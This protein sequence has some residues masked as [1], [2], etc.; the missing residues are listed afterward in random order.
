MNEHLSRQFEL[1]LDAIRTEA[2]Q[3]GGLV[4]QQLAAALSGLVSADLDLL[5]KVAR[6]EDRV[7]R[8]E[9]DIDQACTRLIA[10]RQPTASDLRLVMGVSRIVTDLERCGDKAA[11]IARMAVKLHRGRE[12]TAAVPQLSNLRRFGE[13]AVALLRRT[14]DALARLD[15]DEAAQIIGADKALDEMFESILRE[16]IT[17]MMEDSRT[18]SRGLDIIWIAKALERVGDHAANIAESVVYVV[19]G[20]D[21]RHHQGDD[22]ADAS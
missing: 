4:E 13:A 14:L 22:G 9:V 16:L 8:Y 21:I 3:M 5:A 6:D 1:E 19:R 11:K 15:A 7:D 18:I 12:G 10:K 2:L 17:Y 20:E